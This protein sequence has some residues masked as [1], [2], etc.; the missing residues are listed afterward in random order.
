MGACNGE[1]DCIGAKSRP[2]ELVLWGELELASITSLNVMVVSVGTAPAPC[3]HSKAL[4]CRRSI[5]SGDKLLAFAFKV[6]L[7]QRRHSDTEPADWSPHTL[8]LWR[9]LWMYLQPRQIDSGGAKTQ[10]LFTSYRTTCE[11]ES[12]CKQ[13]PQAASCLASAFPDFI[14]SAAFQHVWGAK[15]KAAPSLSHYDGLHWLI[16]TSG[17]FQATVYSPLSR[18]TNLAGRFMD[19]TPV[20]VIL[21]FCNQTSC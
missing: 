4:C 18:S 8:H 14:S 20:L 16:S 6:L 12:D 2:K 11:Q 13:M 1:Q 17:W 7:Q 15:Q 21:F 9:N 10:R 3:S 5:G 19:H